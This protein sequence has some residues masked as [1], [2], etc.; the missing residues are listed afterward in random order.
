VRPEEA[1]AVA[2]IA[3]SLTDS[4]I[5]SLRQ[6]F[7]GHLIRPSD[8]GY[9]EARKVW[10]GAFDKR[11]GAIARC[12]DTDDVI[13][14]VNFARESAVLFAARGGGHGWS[15]NSTCDDGL[16]IVQS[17]VARPAGMIHGLGRLCLRGGGPSVVVGQAGQ[18]VVEAERMDGLDGLAHSAVEDAAAAAGELLVQRG[19]GEALS[20]DLPHPL[21]NAELLDWAGDSPAAQG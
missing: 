18:M 2:Q 3:G 14:A 16:V 5:Q 13:A 8:S 15:G 9:E 1:T 19:P 6:T 4:S 7:K 12:V 10:N 17:P 20:D 21:G 11:P